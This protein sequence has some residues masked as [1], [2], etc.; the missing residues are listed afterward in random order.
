MGHVPN[1]GD[2]SAL[3]RRTPIQIVEDVLIVDDHPL[4]CH[5]LSL[6]LTHAFGLRRVRTASSL[7]TA[8][9]QVADGGA[10]GAIV[11]DL[12][13]PDVEGVEG[14]MVLHRQCGPVPLTV[15]SAD[16]DRDMMD[17][18]MAAGAHGFVS[19]SLPRADM[20]E[21]FRR[22]WGGEIVSPTECEA[23][24]DEGAAQ[25]LRDLSRRF[26]SLT[27][28]QMNILRLICRG[29]PNKLIS[30][31]LSI[32]EATVKT[33][34]AAIMTKVNARNRTQVAL[35]ANKARVFGR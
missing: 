14:I 31:Q 10:P 6:T 12:N 8:L 11:L 29:T 5:A 34:I 32:A 25:A 18:A 22:M 26:A 21:A 2:E 15:I 1:W 35:L 28:Q 17:A 19:K 20:I 23:G 24:V 9:Q 16:I 27:P 7:R 3:L 33:H 13:L 30:Y 4:I